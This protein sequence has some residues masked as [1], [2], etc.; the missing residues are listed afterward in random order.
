MTLAGEALTWAA[1]ATG[2]G[3]TAA[4]FTGAGDVAAGLAGFAGLVEALAVVGRLLTLG[5]EESFEVSSGRS[6]ICVG[7]KAAEGSSGG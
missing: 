5:M 1:L 3:I 4:F 2:L 6:G 7:L